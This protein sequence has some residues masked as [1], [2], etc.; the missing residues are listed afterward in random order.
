MQKIKQNFEKNFAK[1]QLYTL[2]NIFN[3]PTNINPLSMTPL[4]ESSSSSNNNNNVIPDQIEDAEEIELTKTLEKLREK[5]LTAQGEYL[6]LSS[7]CRDMDTLLKEMRN[8]MFNLRVA[9]QSLEDFEILPLSDTTYMITQYQQKLQQCQQDAEDLLSRIRQYE[10]SQ[11]EQKGNSSFFPFAVISFQFVS[12][13][14][15]KDL[16]N[17]DNTESI[18][19]ITRALQGK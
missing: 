1:F 13:E 11:S 7:E 14:Q 15:E 2:R 10:S 17:L 3:P 19:N 16:I 9:L 8:A 12:L 6:H 4:Q 18:V 5:Y